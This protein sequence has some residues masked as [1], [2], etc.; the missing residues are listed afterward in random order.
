MKKNRMMK[1][2]LAAIVAASLVIGMAGCGGGNNPKSLAKEAYEMQQK[3]IAV[4]SEPDK[5]AA[6]MEDWTKK[7]EAKEKKLSEEEKEI[8][9]EEFK[10]LS[11]N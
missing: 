2:L 3:I 7:I 5:V 11:G 8:Y 9:L 1:G 4:S 10:R 6:L